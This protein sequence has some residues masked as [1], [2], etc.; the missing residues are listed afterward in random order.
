[1]REQ[2]RMRAPFVKPADVA[3]EQRLALGI[4][5]RPI[6][7]CGSGIVLHGFAEGD[8]VKHPV[9]EL[10]DLIGAHEL[11][12]LRLNSPFVPAEA[13]SQTWKQSSAWPLGPRFRG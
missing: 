2:E 5:E 1:M 9:A 3:L 11:V 4:G 13:G 7:D 10:V 8:V 12:S 6:R